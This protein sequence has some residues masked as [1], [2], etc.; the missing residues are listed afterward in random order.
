MWGSHLPTI[1][2]YTYEYTDI[3]ESIQQF[4][5]VPLVLV[6]ALEAV[7]PDRAP[8]LTCQDR[9]VWYDAGSVQVVRF[10][11]GKYEEQ[12]EHTNVP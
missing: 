6:E 10:L 1:F 4:P 12:Q 11:R 7:F 2:L 3:M 5:P 8:R 9:K